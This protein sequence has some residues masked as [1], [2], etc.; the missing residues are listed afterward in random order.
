MF[1]KTL[2]CDVIAVPGSAEGVLALLVGAANS[3]LPEGEFKVLPHFACRRDRNVF[4]KL[5]IDLAILE[6]L[7]ERL[8]R[9]TG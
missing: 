5:L 3:W 8:L 4:S 2:T 9:E 6:V 1:V 7:R